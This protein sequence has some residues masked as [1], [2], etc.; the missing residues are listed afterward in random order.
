MASMSI[1]RPSRIRRSSSTMATRIGGTVGPGSV[2]ALFADVMRT[3]VLDC[4]KADNACSCAHPPFDR[5]GQRQL[6]ALTGGRAGLQVSAKL[7]GAR[8]HALEAPAA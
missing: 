1:S 7:R 6:R 3:T 5:H 4:V 2:C 8:G